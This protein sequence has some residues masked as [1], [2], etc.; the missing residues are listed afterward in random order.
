MTTSL[1]INTKVNFKPNNLYTACL[2]K[3]VEQHDYLDNEQAYA[4][5]LILEDALPRDIITDFYRVNNCYQHAINANLD[6]LYKLHFRLQKHKL[7]PQ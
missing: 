4:F 5:S 3:L 2:L 1:F 7:S 6:L